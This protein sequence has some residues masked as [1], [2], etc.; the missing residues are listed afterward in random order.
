MLPPSPFTTRQARDAGFS[1]EQ[2]RGLVRRRQVR[3]IFRGVYQDASQVE[4]PATRCRAARLILPSDVIVCDRTAAWMHGVDALAYW[5]LDQVVPVEVVRLPTMSRARRVDVAAGERDLVARDVVEIHGVRITTPLRTALDLGC[6]LKRH[7]AMATIDGLMRVGSVEPHQLL[8]ELPRFRGRRGVIQLRSLI[9]AAD[10]AAESPGESWLRLAI[11]DA[12]LLR[13]MAQ[14]WVTDDGVRVYRLDLAY[15][16]L[17]ICIEYDGVQFHSDLD[18]VRR[19][20]E[21]RAWLRARGWLVIV[22]RGPDLVGDRRER[23]LEELRQA[24]TVASRSTYRR[25]RFDVP[26]ASKA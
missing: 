4:T 8:D 17:R 26:R 3:R 2:L 24:I 23:W 6:K 15:P 16:K 13:P 14:Y 21:R 11:L 18:Q 19:D 22:V 25:G 7:H 20:A 1:V 12:G 5:E 9:Q 10:P